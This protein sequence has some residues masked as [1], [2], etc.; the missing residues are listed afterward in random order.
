[1]LG[2]P[3]V[4]SGPS[5]LTRNMGAVPVCLRFDEDVLWLTS[6]EEARSC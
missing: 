6:A 1:M 5:F 2:K 3:L 4:L